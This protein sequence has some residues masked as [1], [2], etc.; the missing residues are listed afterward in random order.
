[1]QASLGMGCCREA[2]VVAVC[3]PSPLSPNHS[4]YMKTNP[5]RVSSLLEAYTPSSQVEASWYLLSSPSRS[6]I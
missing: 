3:H 6:M 2:D 1:M 4:H 5:Y